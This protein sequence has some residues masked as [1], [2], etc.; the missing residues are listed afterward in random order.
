ME[1]VLDLPPGL[2]PHD[3]AAFEPVAHA[4]VAEWPA[5]TFLENLAVLDDGDIAVSVLSEARIDRVSQAGV[6][7]TLIALAAPP[8]GLALLDGALFAAVG[9]PGEEAATLWRIDPASGRGEPWMTIDGSRFINGLTPFDATRLIA[10]DSLQ[11]RI[12]VIDPLARSSRVWF[13]DERL[14]PIDDAP[15]FPG[16]NGVKRRGDVVFVASN[17]RASMLGVQVTADGEAGVARVVAARLRVDDFAFDV[18]GNLYLTT[19][20][21]NS[22]DRLSPDGT[23]VTLAGLDQGMAGSTA[24]AFGR[25]GASRRAL[26]VTTTGGIIGPPNG[27]V[28]AARLVRL[29]IEAEGMPLIAVRR[30]R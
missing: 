2:W 26:Y 4:I 12:Y 20:I 25:S 11:G 22:L 7:S 8:T 10:T 14:L 19:H 16:A 9:A 28:Q 21:H 13:E 29:E 1:P 5:G 23:R 15:G 30:A 18:A 24:C 27:V 3:P 6:R 17:G